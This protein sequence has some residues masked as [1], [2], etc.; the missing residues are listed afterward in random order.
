MFISIPLDI[1]QCAKNKSYFDMTACQKWM[2]HFFIWIKNATPRCRRSS[3][4]I[5]LLILHLSFLSLGI[6]RRTV[7][8]KYW[9]CDLMSA[10]TPP[11]KSSL[12][13]LIRNY[14]WVAHAM[15]TH[16][17]THSTQTNWI[18]FIF[19]C[20][21]SSFRFHSG[22]RKTRRKKRHKERLQRIQSWI[23]VAKRRQSR[24][25]SIIAQQRRCSDS[26]CTIAIAID[27]WRNINSNRTLNSLFLV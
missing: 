9:N 1:V 26:W 5:Y 6:R 19:F 22:S 21:L 12:K 16:I 3:R 17:P 20:F 14:W 4:S 18:Y 23:P 10:N 15:T 24:I 2:S 11:K 8:T 7:T 27:R 25:H 13:L